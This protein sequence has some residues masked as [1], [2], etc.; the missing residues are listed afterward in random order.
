M[1]N[2]HF[3]LVMYIH[4]PSTTTQIHAKALYPTRNTRKEL[5]TIYERIPCSPCTKHYRELIEALPPP[6]DAEELFKWSVEAHNQVNERLSKPKVNEERAR[7][8][9]EVF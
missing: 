6:E 8:G 3:F 1:S 4:T 2:S 9:Y 5:L 7:L